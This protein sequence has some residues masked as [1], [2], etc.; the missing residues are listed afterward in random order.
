MLGRGEESL[1]IGLLGSPRFPDKKLIPTQIFHQIIKLKL[2]DFGDMAKIGQSMTNH[3]KINTIDMKDSIEYSYKYQDDVY[4]YRHVFLPPLIAK[5][6]P[7]RLLSEPEWRALGVQQSLGWVHYTIHGPEPH[8]L[9]FRRLRNSSI[10][11]TNVLIKDKL[12][13]K[14]L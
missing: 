11:P 4:E 7:N 9:L 13:V 12:T 2:F 8:I 6:L 10:L 5:K 14:S 3:P 1:S